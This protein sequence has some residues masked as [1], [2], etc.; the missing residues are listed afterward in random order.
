MLDK[1]YD[2]NP[3]LNYGNKGNRNAALFLIQK[4]GVGKTME[5]VDYAISV[6][7]EKYAPQIATPHQLKEKLAALFKY[8]RDNQAQ[9]KT[10]VSI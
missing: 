9:Q 6:Q 8:Y 3:S 2:I 5:V 7:S 10:L 1:F 4:F